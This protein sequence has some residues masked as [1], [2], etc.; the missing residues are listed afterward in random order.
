[1][2]LYFVPKCGTKSLKSKI[3]SEGWVINFNISSWVHQIM[4][5][6]EIPTLS[7][8]CVC[9]L[10]KPNRLHSRQIKD[11]TCILF[12][13]NVHI[14]CFLRIVAPSMSVRFC[15][16]VFVSCSVPVCSGTVSLVSC[17]H[18][19]HLLKPLFT[20]LFLNRTSR[21][22]PMKSRRVSASLKAGGTTT[23]TVS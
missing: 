21:V 12:L 16:Y 11:Q 22:W 18:I 13:Y 15:V 7:N 3:K 8:L 17:N 9:V 19:I 23:T 14:F 5:K 10:E 1:M 6:K 20:F 4:K 2:R